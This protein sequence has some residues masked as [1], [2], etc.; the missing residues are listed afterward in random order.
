[1]SIPA[2]IETDRPMND[3]TRRP[4]KEALKQLIR[5]QAPHAY[6]LR[7]RL[8]R[9]FIE[10]M[11]RDQPFPAHAQYMLDRVETMIVS[12]ERMTAFWS[13]AIRTTRLN[14]VRTKKHHG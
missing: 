5:E 11:E 14:Q 10:C 3:E 6:A 7:D 13:S 8:R 9:K 12:L 2:L 4:D 1:M